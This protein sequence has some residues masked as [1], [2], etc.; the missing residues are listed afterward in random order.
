MQC[1][2]KPHESKQ[3][4]HNFRYFFLTHPSSKLFF[5]QDL[6]HCN[7]HYINHLQ[8]AKEHDIVLHH[9][10]QI[11]IFRQRCWQELL[12]PS[13]EAPKQSTLLPTVFQDLHLGTCVSSLPAAQAVTDLL[14]D[15]FSCFLKH[16]P[17]PTQCFTST[18]KRMLRIRHF[19][20]GEKQILVQGSIALM[21]CSELN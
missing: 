21:R 10:Q 20:P 15:G 12:A 19:P 2:I 11:S 8:K 13:A 17:K 9:T 5:K 3:V 4:N 14:T 7:I 18:N 1:D 16:L 6:T